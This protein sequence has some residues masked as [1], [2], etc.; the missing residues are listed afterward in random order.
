MGKHLRHL[1]HD[2]Q[3]ATLEMVWIFMTRP[4]LWSCD[5]PRWLPSSSFHISL[6]Y[7]Q[8]K[9]CLLCGLMIFY[10]FTEC[11]QEIIS[12]HLFAETPSRVADFAMHTQKC[13]STTAFCSRVK[14]NVTSRFA[15]LTR[16]CRYKR[17]RVIT[18]QNLIW[19][20]YLWLCVIRTCFV[21]NRVLW[22]IW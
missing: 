22:R 20:V 14:R 16:S 5:V 6:S 12:S 19:N 7:C 11:C 8:F 13:P 9:E 4:S 1:S 17:G 21:M 18:Q 15:L 2:F 10:A 3:F